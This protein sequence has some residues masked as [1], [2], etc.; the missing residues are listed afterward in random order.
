MNVNVSLM[1][2]DFKITAWNILYFSRLKTTNLAN[3]F[4]S[5]QFFVSILPS[6]AHYCDIKNT[7]Y[8][9]KFRNWYLTYAG[10]LERL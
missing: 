3:S 6:C 5:S 7:E 1:F 2:D 4:N 8:A 9:I 10:I